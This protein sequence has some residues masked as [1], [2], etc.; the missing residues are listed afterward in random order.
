MA[1][2]PSPGHRIRARTLPFL[3]VGRLEPAP[4]WPRLSNRTRARMAVMRARD[5][6]PGSWRTRQLLVAMSALGVLIAGCASAKA[7]SQV[8]VQRRPV[9][10]GGH[11]HELG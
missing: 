5:V 8:A 7:P 3:V 11:G 2:V 9:Q 6:S 4:G 10:P 1:G